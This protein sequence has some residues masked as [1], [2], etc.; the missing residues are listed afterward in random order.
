V[1]ADGAA[2]RCSA[3]R[4][5]VTAVSRVSAD[6]AAARCS[7]DRWTAVAASQ[8]SA[9]GAAWPARS[10]RALISPASLADPPAATTSSVA[11]TPLDSGGLG[12][13]TRDPGSSDAVAWCSKSPTAVANIMIFNPCVRASLGKF[14]ISM[15]HGV[16]VSVFGLEISCNSFPA[17][18]L[19][20]E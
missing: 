8:G 15:L 7:A 9:D 18:L 14:V 16:V 13:R 4:W 12:E 10:I 1:S 20:F 17:G 5:I 19:E 11:A 2:A 6:G 3:D